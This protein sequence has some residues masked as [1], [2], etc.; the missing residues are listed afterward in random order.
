MGRT[1]RR[2]VKKFREDFDA[3]IPQEPVEDYET[4]VAQHRRSRNAKHQS[5]LQ[6]DDVYAT[7]RD[8]QDV[9]LSDD[10]PE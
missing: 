10:I 8:A 4:L 7:H 6:H 1:F 2:E 5:R 3:D 9:P